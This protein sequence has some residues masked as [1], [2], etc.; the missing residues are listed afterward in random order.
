M[1]PHAILMEKNVKEIILKRIS[2]ALT[3]TI[4]NI[5]TTMFREEI[6]WFKIQVIYEVKGTA[7]KKY[8]HIKHSF[9]NIHL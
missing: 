4:N 1:V 3:R 8:T 6:V 2:R 5:N 7:T 9:K